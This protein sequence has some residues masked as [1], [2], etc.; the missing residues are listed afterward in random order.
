MKNK[1]YPK[2]A[3]FAFFLAQLIQ[4]STIKAQIHADFTA[5]KTEGCSPII[6]NFTNLS[7]PE[8]GLSY[9]WDFGNGSTSATQNPSVIFNEP[10]FFTIKLVITDGVL[11]DS[12]IRTDYIEV[13]ANPT[14]TFIISASDT[15]CAPYSVT[16]IDQSLSQAPIVFWHWDF[17]DGS[18]SL[19]QNPQHTY[20]FQN[21]FGVSLFIKDANNCQNT[22]FAD[23]FIH[24]Y[25]PTAD[26]SVTDSFNCNGTLNANFINNS[27]NANQF[28]WNFGNG[29]TSD[30]QNPECFYS[31]AGLFTVSLIAKGGYTCSDTL[32][33]THYINIKNIEANFSMPDDTVCLNATV[34][35]TNLSENA[36]TYF[37]DFGNGEISYQRNTSGIFNQT[38]I[39]PV[40]LEVGSVWGCSDTLI[41]NIYVEKIIAEFHSVDS[42]SC[43]V[44]VDVHYLNTSTNADTYLWHF[45]DGLTSPDREPI[46]TFTESGMYFDTLFVENRHGCTAVKIAER[47]FEV[48]VLQAHITPN[49]FVLTNELSGCVP[50]TINFKDETHYATASD[51]IF[52]RTWNFGDNT[53]STEQN[54]SHTYT[55]LDTF[56]ITLDIVSL[57]GCTSSNIVSAATGTPQT[58]SFVADKPPTICASENV[59]FTSTSTNVN[60]IN[61]YL[62][63][64][65][66]NT[67]STKMYPLKQFT[68]TG[69]FDVS[70]TVYNNGCGA[71]ITKENLFYVKGPVAKTTVTYHCENNFTPSFSVDAKDFESYSWDFGDGSPLVTT[72]LN[73]T[74]TY[75]ERGIFN[76]TFHAL[77]NTNSCVFDVSDIVTITDITA[78]IAQADTFG[79]LNQNFNFDASAS[80]DASTIQ[81]EN[82]I[83]LYLWD[84]DDGSPIQIS[85]TIVNHTYRQKGIFYP[86]VKVCDIHGCFDSVSTRILISKPDVIFTTES[87]L[88]CMPMLVEFSNQTQADTTIAAW[89]W[90]FGDGNFSAE[91]NPAHT[92]NEFGIYPV[93]LTATDRINC[94]SELTKTDFIRALR[95]SPDFFS[96]DRTQCFG[97]T[98]RLFSIS[99][100]I[101]T[102]YFWDYG[103]GYVSGAAQPEY[104]YP[105][106]GSYTV[107]LKLVDD[108]GCDSML[109]IANF[110]KVQK[111]PIAEFS[112][113]TISSTCFPFIVQF[114]DYSI[115]P[116]LASWHWNFGFGNASSELQNPIY[117]YTRPGLYDVKLTAYSS[118][119]CAAENIKSNYIDVGGPYAEF[120]FP[121]TVC[122]YTDILFD[123]Y[124]EFNVNSFKWFLGDGRTCE[125]DSGIYHFGERGTLFPTLFLTAD[126]EHTCDKF[127]SDTV[128]IR[129][130]EIDIY[131][132][133]TFEGCTPFLAEFSNRTDES[134]SQY[135]DFGNGETSSTTNTHVTYENAGNYTLRFIV[136]DIKLC[137]DT[138]FKNIIVNPLPNVGITPDT[139]ICL[140]ETVQLSA[141]GA[142][143]YEWIPARYLDNATLS[144][145]ISMPDS[146]I[147][148]Y[149][150]ATDTNLCVNYAH[151]NIKVQQHPYV[152]LRDTAVI[153]GETVQF[154]ATAD[155]IGNYEWSPTASLNCSDCP[156]VF[157]QATEPLLIELFYTDTAACF[158]EKTQSHIE[159]RK[160]YSLDMPTAFSPNND[161]VNDV[162]FVRGWG[163]K[164]IL[165]YKI[166]NR[167]GEMVFST[168]YLNEGWDGTYKGKNQ[169]IETY[170]YNVTVLNYDDKIL[171]KK[172]N[173][174][175]IK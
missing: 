116:Q 110:L 140:G 60:L 113:D 39:Y 52:S 67:I 20:S 88:G 65:G 58:A 21:N 63:Q 80:F 137:S 170:I 9:Y 111:P 146:S 91:A 102:E 148:Y 127:F 85:D 122:T 11:Q 112:A 171:T 61:G 100:E 12:L 70:L 114:S 49:L 31:Q 24:V 14:P 35:F 51:Y 129:K 38:G 71:K 168:Q 25:K 28:V 26:F 135:W 56:I 15:G 18:E 81:I 118:F 92:Y 175:L 172:G 19:L 157:Y 16:F 136:N 13:F 165:E 155:D 142:E 98:A 5:D 46:H 3:F 29:Q 34:Q 145:P 2:I 117:T 95:P 1:V 161:G 130:P 162:L 90:D 174:K 59:Q 108:A 77:N 33:R 73:P 134:A 27:S 121:D 8:T 82:L 66:D 115:H 139:L 4:F 123:K 96:P 54:P 152:E 47:P 57:R 50:L 99:N 78:D 138:V 126:D 150:A 7:N 23:N 32:I 169:N 45:A 107:T 75:T 62:W 44:P 48:A 156:I 6:V 22:L 167:Y 101:I 158:T 41:K 36:T 83:G 160:E 153:I 53:S 125:T 166:F 86:K 74:H 40:R 87:M 147:V 76:S 154:D 30:E 163:I 151:T 84:F 109:T 106:S 120:T 105:D 141:S 164:Q 149:V 119:G 17:G 64:F 143:N 131:A 89:Q 144:N 159:I 72:T 94:T 69:Y 10:G 55:S 173:V 133:Y 93:K 79:C 103:N 37:W 43:T 42:F 128:Y 97:D 68:D 124:N 104:V 132:P